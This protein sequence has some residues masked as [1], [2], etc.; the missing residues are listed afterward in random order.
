M[1]A[2]SG[3]TALSSCQTSR[4]R[5]ALHCHAVMA[6]AGSHEW[7]VALQGGPG[8]PRGSPGAGWGQTPSAAAHRQTGAG[9]AG[10]TAEAEPGRGSVVVTWRGSRGGGVGPS[11]RRS[12][13]GERRSGEGGQGRREGGGGARG[14]GGRG[15]GARGCE[16]PP[17]APPSRPAEVSAGE[18]RHGAGPQGGGAAGGRLGRAGRCTGPR[19]LRGCF[20]F[21][22]VGAGGLSVLRGRGVPGRRRD[23]RARGVLCAASFPWPLPRAPNGHGPG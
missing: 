1:V 4:Y 2:A 21:V 20:S 10:E 5:V 8:A 17:P 12:G 14:R 13:S 9:A 6:L 16:W 23:V 15:E 3:P 18:P 19:Q 22:P 11:R 7:A